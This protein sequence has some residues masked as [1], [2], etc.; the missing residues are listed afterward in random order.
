MGPASLVLARALRG[1]P[2]NGGTGG[3]FISISRR[4]SRPSSTP[5]Y[6]STRSSKAPL[7]GKFDQSRRCSTK[8]T[9]AKL[10]RSP[11]WRGRY[12]RFSS[13]RSAKPVSTI[14]V[15][16][17]S[18]ATAAGC[19][20]LFAVS[21]GFAGAVSAAIEPA[22]LTIE[23]KI[24]LGDVRGRIDHLAI[25]LAR[26][27]LFAAELGNNSLSIVDLKGQKVLHRITGLN[28]IGRASCR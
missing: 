14:E 1:S 26:Q 10:R 11:G 22:P 4:R 18:I 3:Q 28:E 9:S 15:R 8:I 17:R 6:S 5:T 2:R 12:G 13:P 24:P 20:G 16:N 19:C 7:N 27:R 21:I 23:A 25:D